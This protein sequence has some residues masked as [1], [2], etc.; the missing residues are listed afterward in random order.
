MYCYL[1]CGLV[2]SCK[3]IAT[4]TIAT[5][6]ARTATG[7]RRALFHAKIAGS[8]SVR[9]VM[10]PHPKG[11]ES[12]TSQVLRYRRLGRAGRKTYK[13][14]YLLPCNLFSAHPVNVSGV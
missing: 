10:Y 5:L 9:S 14:Y 8:I 11:V 13:Y 2:P 12:P 1:A 6:I 4:R 3:G 7:F